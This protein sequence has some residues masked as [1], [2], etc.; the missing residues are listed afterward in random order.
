MGRRVDE[1]VCRG[2][3]VDLTNLRDF[4][5]GWDIAEIVDVASFQ[6]FILVACELCYMEPVSTT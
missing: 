6:Y 4:A 2:E 1:G 3:P 5:F